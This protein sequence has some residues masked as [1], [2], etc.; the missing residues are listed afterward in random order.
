MQSLQL[1]AM[2]RVEYVVLYHLLTKVLAFIGYANRA[3]RTIERLPLTKVVGMHA[4]LAGKSRLTSLL[5]AKPIRQFAAS[6]P[7]AS[8]HAARPLVLM[9]LH[10][11]LTIERSVSIIIMNERAL[12]PCCASETSSCDLSRSR[13]FRQ[14]YLRAEC[15]RRAASCAWLRASIA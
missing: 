13:D 4:M 3:S 10:K 15:G 1:R 7:T 12:P 14:P 11:L 8:C 5:G 2:R 9:I 6:P